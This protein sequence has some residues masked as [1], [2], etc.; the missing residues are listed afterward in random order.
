MPYYFPSHV[1]ITQELLNSS[2]LINETSESS[3]KT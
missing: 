2:F 1:Y 3:Y